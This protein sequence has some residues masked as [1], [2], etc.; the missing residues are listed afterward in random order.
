MKRIRFAD[1]VPMAVE[2]STVP[3]D[4][5]AAVD[6]VEDS[7]YDAMKANGARPANVA[8]PLVYYRVSSG[9]YQRRGGRD[10]LRAE[11]R[12]QRG[13]RDAGMTSGVQYVRNVAIR[14]GYR[15]VPWR[16]RRTLYTAMVATR[17]ARAN[18]E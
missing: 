6:A 17:F 13:M 9:A 8:E 2:H 5:L 18:D 11:L 10:L 14:G 12:L 7:L 4:S 3:A 1:D 16:L 15:L